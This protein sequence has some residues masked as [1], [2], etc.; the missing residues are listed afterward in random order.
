MPRRYL[1]LCLTPAFFNLVFNL[2]GDGL[3]DAF[4]PRTRVR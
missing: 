2:V 3:R 4:D 1:L